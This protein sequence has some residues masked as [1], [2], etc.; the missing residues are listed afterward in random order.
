MNPAR[1]LEP[2]YSLN[3]KLMWSYPD[4]GITA[5]QML[6]KVRTLVRSIL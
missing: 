4:I 5:D 2:S 6:E 3:P 1:I